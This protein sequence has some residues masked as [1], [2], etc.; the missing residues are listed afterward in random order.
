MFTNIDEIVA[1]EGSILCMTYS[2]D[3]GMLVTGSDDCTLRLWPLGETVDENEMMHDD[4]E[5]GGRRGSTRDADD[6]ESRELRA[7]AYTRPLLSST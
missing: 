4:E 2:T 7:W 3:L 5:E 6:Q 1:H